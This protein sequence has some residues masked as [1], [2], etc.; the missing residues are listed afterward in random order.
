MC[1]LCEKPLAVDVAAAERM[2]AAA[3][4]HQ[5]ILGTVF[6]RR[7]WP[8][9]QNIRAAIDDGLLGTPMLGPARSCSTVA[10]TTTAPPVGAEPGRPTV[11]EC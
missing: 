10:R 9:A 2:V 5:I 7:F 4:Q 1:L 8:A 11:A 6:Q 3:E